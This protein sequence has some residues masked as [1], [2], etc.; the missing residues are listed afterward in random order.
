M[1]IKISKT[2]K[3]YKLNNILSLITEPERP[4][5]DNSKRYPLN[6]WT[7]GTRHATYSVPCHNQRKKRRRRRAL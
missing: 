4:Q 3:L 6:S 1:I 5:E 7:I 2:I